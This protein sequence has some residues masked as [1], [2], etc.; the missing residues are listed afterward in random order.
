MEAFHVLHRSL[1][2]GPALRIEDAE[3]LLCSICDCSLPSLRKISCRRIDCRLRRALPAENN[4]GLDLL[5]LN[6]L[7]IEPHVVAGA[8]FLAIAVEVE[9]KL[10][11]PVMGDAFDLPRA[12]VPL[13]VPE[14]H[15]IESLSRILIGDLYRALIGESDPDNRAVEAGADRLNHEADPVAVSKIERPHIEAGDEAA[16]C[17]IESVRSIICPDFAVRPVLRPGVSMASEHAILSSGLTFTIECPAG[18]ILAIPDTHASEDLLFLVDTLDASICLRL[19]REMHIE[20]IS[21]SLPQLFSHDRNP[22]LDQASIS[23][24]PSVSTGIFPGSTLRPIA[25]LAGTFSAP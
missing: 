7:D 22:P 13:I 11:E 16:E 15:R 20:R 4:I 10:S 14:V 1:K 3:C 2:H 9:G 21:Y 8:H 23:K 18:H 6:I 12:V 25:D 24:S 5:Q 19:Q 17:R